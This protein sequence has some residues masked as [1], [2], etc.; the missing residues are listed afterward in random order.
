MYN[1]FVD[2]LE[3]QRQL[4]EINQNIRIL[5][6]KQNYQYTDIMLLLKTVEDKLSN[7]SKEE[8][9]EIK[10]DEKL[11]EEVREL[12]I[13]KGLASTSYIQQA[14]CIGYAKVARL[15][16]MLEINGVIEEQNGAKHRKVLIKE[17]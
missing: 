8:D 11:Y 3:L 6:E 7:K 5:T 17:V 9:L 2:D 4:H 12:V 1:F 13:K 10:A 16:D 15:I 14:L